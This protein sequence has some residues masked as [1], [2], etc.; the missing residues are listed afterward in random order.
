[1]LKFAVAGNDWFVD[2]FDKILFDDLLLKT[3][4][5]SKDL[6]NLDDFIDTSKL[7]DAPAAKKPDSGLNGN[8]VLKFIKAHEGSVRSI[9]YTFIYT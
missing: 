4:G 6:F 8:Q 7:K 2:Q 5:N 1:M 9:T 3:D